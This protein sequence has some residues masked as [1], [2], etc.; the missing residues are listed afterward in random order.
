MT[1]RILALL[2]TLLMVIPVQ[3]EI[4]MEAERQEDA[5]LMNITRSHARC[6]VVVQGAFSE[7]EVKAVRKVF[8]AAM[9]SNI[10]KMMRGHR[11]SK[12]ISPWPDIINDD[13][14]IGRILEEMT[15]EARISPETKTLQKKYRHD[16]KRVNK[17]LWRERNCDAI[18]DGLRGQ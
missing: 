12:L 15:Y 1:T 10:K 17:E 5:R 7:N 2:L 4:D 6:S 13:M 8:Y 16:H 14:H 3:A 9:I 18:Y 11:G